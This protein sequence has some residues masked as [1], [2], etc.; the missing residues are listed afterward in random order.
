V[1]VCV[2]IVYTY[3]YMCVSV[4]ACVYT[5]ICVCV[6]IYIYI[7]MC[8]FVFIHIYIHIYICKTNL[9]YQRSSPK[10]QN[11][12]FILNLSC[13][14]VRIPH[15]WLSKLIG[16]SV[17]LIEL[18]AKFMVLQPPRSLICFVEVKLQRFLICDF[19]VK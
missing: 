18:K 14:D 2:C 13:V 9:C 16:Y 8:V 5:Y 7:Y 1:C 3:I 12:K 6:Y 4:C 17:S 19:Q 11:T 10:T 15:F